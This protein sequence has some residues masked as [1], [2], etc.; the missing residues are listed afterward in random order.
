MCAVARLGLQEMARTSQ[1]G[2]SRSPARGY[3]YLGL[4]FALALAGYFFA[5]QGEVV[6]TAGQ[7]ERETELVFRGGE[8]QRAIEAYVR[9]T[10]TGA[11][12][13]PETLEDLLVDR[14][15]VQP[16]HH[17]RRLYL[18]PFTQQPD[19]ELLP[20]PAAPG[21]FEGVRSRAKVKPLRLPP[22]LPSLPSDAKLASSCVCAWPFVA[23]P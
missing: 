2:N 1:A 8:I 4:L 16:R 7:R 17:L 22:A 19:W 21:G 13:W 14:R 10:P 11:K 5:R 20:A 12:R 9:T 15:Q 18:D 3:T 23:R 6:G